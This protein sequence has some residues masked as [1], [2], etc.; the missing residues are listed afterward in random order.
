MKKKTMMALGATMAVVMLLLYITGDLYYKSLMEETFRESQDSH[1]YTYKFDMIVENQE[2]AFWQ[3]VYKSARKNAAKNDV[4]LEL[5]GAGW[6][7]DYDKIDFMNMSIASQPDGIILEY[8]GEPGLK[9]KID[10][11]ADKGIPVVTVMNDAGRSRRQSFIGVSEYQLGTAYGEQ[12]VRY[13]DENTENILILVNREIDDMSRSHLYTQ[14]MN[15]VT[16]NVKREQ[17]I[18]VRMENLL[19]AGSFETEEVISDLF[20][21]SEEIPDILICMD[22]ETTEC[23]R[24]SVLNFNLAGKVKIIG[25]YISEDILSA[26]EKGI[27]SVTCNVDTEQLGRYSV[28]ALTDYLKEGRS[29][30]YYSVDLSFVGKDDVDRIRREAIANETDQVE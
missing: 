16:R 10:E 9:E 6:K 11:A 7:T 24:Q 4:L 17:R 1:R 12:V 14:I 5:K 21:K 2:S 27:I 22:E 23:V 30:S 29:S 20:Q 28:E 18:D 15:A 25:Y 3:E 19:P 26:V 8:N 13:M